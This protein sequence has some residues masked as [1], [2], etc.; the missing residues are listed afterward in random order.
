MGLLKTPSKAMLDGLIVPHTFK[1]CVGHIAGVSNAEE[2]SSNVTSISGLGI[3]LAPTDLKNSSGGEAIRVPTYPVRGP[4]SIT[5]A[6]RV[7]DRYWRSELTKLA[8]Y[9][10]N[11]DVI[12][13]SS[14][15]WIYMFDMYKNPV[16]IIELQNA[17]ISDY[18][19]DELNVKNTG[20]VMERAQ[21]EFMNMVFH[22]LT[23]P[24][25]KPSSGGK[26]GQYIN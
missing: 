24:E 21:L 11:K 2:G 5:N 6:L 13:Y 20:F 8:G 19:I 17:W 22:E 3:S 10:C 14:Y 26:P 15:V 12:N 25:C 23:E 16:L 7:K 9:A 4:V 18:R 1:V